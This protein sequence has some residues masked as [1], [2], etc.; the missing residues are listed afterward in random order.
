[1]TGTVT[2]TATGQEAPEPPLLRIVKGDPSPEELAALVAVVST[3]SAGTP[4]AGSP[5]TGA[6]AAGN[7][8]PTP[9]W[10]AHHRKLRGTHRHAP[11]AW[12]AT[13]RAV[14]SR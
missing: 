8:M 9:E 4:W 5:S 6:Q 10:G 2:G 11:G 7:P 1:V 14:N 3:L 12:R 13:A